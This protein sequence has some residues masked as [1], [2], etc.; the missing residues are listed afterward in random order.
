MLRGWANQHRIHMQIELDNCVDGEEYEEI[1]AFKTQCSILYR[2]IMWRT[3]HGV[4]VQPLIGK[5]RFFTS[6]ADAM[7]AMTLVV[8]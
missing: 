8:S 2:W 3:V 1:L 5:P 6:V 4:T 7:E